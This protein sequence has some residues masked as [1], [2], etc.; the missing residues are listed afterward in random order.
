MDIAPKHTIDAV[1]A[2]GNGVVLDAVMKCQSVFEQ[3][4]R[5]VVSISGGG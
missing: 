5:P 1:M 4:N 2:S 3:H